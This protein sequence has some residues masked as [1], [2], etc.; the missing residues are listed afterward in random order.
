MTEE[1]K[2][3]LPGSDRNANRSQSKFVSI[4]LAI[5]LIAVLANI[6]IGLMPESSKKGDTGGAVLAAE[7]RKKLAL[8]LEKQGLN[9]SAVTAW[10]EYIAAAT[11]EDEDAARIW[12]RIGKLYQDETKYDLALNSFYRSEL[13]AKSEDISS[14]VARRIQECL[15]AMGKFAALRYELSNRVEMNT[16]AGG[17]DSRVEGDKV[18][19]EIGPQKIMKSDLDRVIEHRIEQQISQV[20]AYLPE[21]QVNKKKEEMLKQLST[22]DQRKMFLNQYLLEE[23][24]YRKARESRLVD[25]TQ[26]RAELKDMERSMLAAKVI[27]KELAESIKITQG[28]LETYYEANKRDYVRPERARISHILLSNKQT[29]QDLRKKLKNGKDFA[30]LARDLSRDPSTGKNGGELSEW[31]EKNEAGQVPGIGNS[32]DAMAAIFSTDEGGI[33][34]E[35]IE[36]DE[37][38]HII[39]VLKREPES[40]KK[41]DEVKNEVFVA[42]R[43]RKE[44]EVQQKL[45]SSLKE[46]YDVVVHSSA[47][48]GKDE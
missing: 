34:E 4:L 38:V 20:A 28:D 14:E 42:L 43:S 25:D 7:Q 37:G 13:F 47:F 35:E 33:V 16:K 46:Q 1:L 36:T 5:V 12:Y 31:V 2:F 21:D 3:N 29:A 22:N 15:E 23:I 24:L 9:A 45:F 39:K 44:R 26:V 48:A 18:V 27:A 41:F 32:E 17:E 10:K 6:G 11:L 40:Q 8:K 19:A 30:A